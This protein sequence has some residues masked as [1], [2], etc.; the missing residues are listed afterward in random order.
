MNSKYPIDTASSLTFA[1]VFEISRSDSPS[2]ETVRSKFFYEQF[3]WAAAHCQQFLNVTACQLLANLCT[4]T[5]YDDTSSACKMYSQ[6]YSSL[7]GDKVHG[8]TGWKNGLPFIKYT[9]TASEV[10]LNTDITEMVGLKGRTDRVTRLR[11][12]LSKFAMN[13][14]WLGFEDLTTQLQL[15][16]VG[17]YAGS[18]FLEFGINYESDCFFNTLSLPNL[19]ETVLYEMCKFSQEQNLTF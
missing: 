17:N 3:Y 14:T 12:I 2:T 10:L 19:P 18:N 9:G 1:Q 13:G 15:C 8:F 16:P 4:L 7:T 5:L 6:V 11:F